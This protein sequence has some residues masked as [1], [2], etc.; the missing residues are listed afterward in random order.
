[1]I[2]QPNNLHH[3]TI[4][5][6]IGTGLSGLVGS[7]FVQLYRNKYQIINLDLHDQDHPVDITDGK[8]VLKAITNSAT[9]FIIH[10]AAFTNVT[11]AWE[12]NGNKDGL[13][14][15]VNVVG[16]QNIAQAA[17]KTGKHLIYI[18]T[19]Y[20]FDGTKTGL[21]RET[22]QPKPI[23]WY[24]QTKLLAEKIVRQLKTPW[25]I[26]RID[27]PFR[28]DAAIRP[29]VVRRV[30]TK[31]QAN[32]LPPQF[33]DHFIG[34]TFIDDF[35][36]IVDFIIRKKVTGLFHASSGESWT[37]YNFALEIAKK[38]ELEDR[39]RQGSLREYLKT[40]NRPYQKNTA[41]SITKLKKIIDF[42]LTPIEEAISQ[43]KI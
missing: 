36:K 16:S 21:Y 17:E 3:S 4:I 30:A 28:S 18:S 2:N 24:G 35:V 34:P 8:Q 13:A 25:T 43:L 29:D 15:Q 31:L 14:Y 27:Q 12:Q 11:A 32:N 5:P 20:V 23:E 26:L 10:M 39:V 38:L 40:S 9:R 33:N 6:L 42:R 7:K 41:L 19:A 22:D 37:D 1:M